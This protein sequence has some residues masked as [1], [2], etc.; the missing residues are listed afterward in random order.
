ML[1]NIYFTDFDSK[2]D[3]VIIVKNSVKNE[4][5]TR[6]LLRFDNSSDRSRVATIN[7]V[8]K[9]YNFKKDDFIE[10]DCKLMISHS[11]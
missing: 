8:S 10:I 6:E 2:K 11:S 1:K 9:E 7:Y 3:E 5:I 4:V